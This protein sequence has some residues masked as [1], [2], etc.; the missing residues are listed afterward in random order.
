MINGYT[1]FF[2][3]DHGF[4][5]VPMQGKAERA[6]NLPDSPNVTDSLISKID[7]M[8]GIFKSVG[9]AQTASRKKI[10]E[11]D[12]NVLR[13]LR[14]NLKSNSIRREHKPSIIADYALTVSNNPMADIN[15]DIQTVLGQDIKEGKYKSLKELTNAL[16]Q[17]QKEVWDTI[18]ER[19]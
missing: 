19:M 9:E 17:Y 5:S 14:L 2:V 13:G 6:I 12:K 1:E 15:E 4:I 3:D 10:I 16:F 7:W 18:S 8:P 11:S